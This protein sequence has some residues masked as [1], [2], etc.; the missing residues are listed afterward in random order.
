MKPTH[1]GTIT[2]VNGDTNV[3]LSTD[4]VAAVPEAHRYVEGPRGW[5][6]VVRVVATTHGRQRTVREYGVAGELLRSTV[7]LR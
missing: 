6:P 1:P 2:F 7:Q 5:V 3:V 4:P